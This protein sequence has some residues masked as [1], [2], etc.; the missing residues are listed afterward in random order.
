MPPATSV[1]LWILAGLACLHATAV[2]ADVKEGMNE[3]DLLALKGPPSGKAVMAQRAIYRWPDMQ[4]TVVNG[5]VTKVVTI[6][7]AAAAVE[8]P[9]PSTAGPSATGPGKAREP[10]AKLI[11]EPEQSVRRQIAAQ[12][13]LDGDKPLYA[14]SVLGR[15]LPDLQVAEW[16][17]GIPART[18]GRWTLVTF[19]ATWSGP[20]R[21]AIP[22]FNQ[23]HQELGPYLTV[24]GLTDEPS[25]DVRALTSPKIDYTVALDPAARLKKEL[26]ITGIPHA[27]LVDPKGIVRWQGYPFEPGHTLT[28][29][30]LRGVLAPTLPRKN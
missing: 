24:V 27:I 5:A 25:A 12:F 16:L 30:V 29:D 4:V 10:V 11:P 2:A 9:A 20:S 21:D 17:G 15:A 18:Q 26:E 19:W 1:R 7:P 14:R 22:L 8:A 23:I 13:K 28:L 6:T 3:A